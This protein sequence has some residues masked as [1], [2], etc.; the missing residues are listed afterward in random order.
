MGNQGL[1]FP[2]VKQPEYFDPEHAKILGGQYQVWAMDELRKRGGD[3]MLAMFFRV[4]S[5]LEQLRRLSV[6]ARTRIVFSDE[7]KRVIAS[8]ES[9]GDSLR[10]FFPYHE[11][12]NDGIFFTAEAIDIDSRADPFAHPPN[13]LQKAIEFFEFARD[14]Y[15]DCFQRCRDTTQSLQQPALAL[16]T[17]QLLAKHVFA[18][19]RVLLLRL[20]MHIIQQKPEVRFEA[21]SQFEV[22]PYF[23]EFPPKQVL[24]DNFLDLAPTIR[25]LTVVMN[26]KFLAPDR[27]MT[28]FTMAGNLAVIVGDHE[29]A[30]SYYTT[31]VICSANSVLPRGLE[32]AIKLL[33]YLEE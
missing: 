11:L 25:M 31:A 20:A 9:A 28:M 7:F 14:G 21:A 18:T 6:Q 24:G 12:F 22:G 8:L 13:T 33:H 15:A 27:A 23:K 19:N 3:A 17:D 5:L 26:Q 29:S 32:E 1:V 16:P 30:W 10:D 4:T 2:P